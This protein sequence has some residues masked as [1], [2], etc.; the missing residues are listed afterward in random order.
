MDPTGLIFVAIGAFAVCGAGFDW[1]FFMNNRK[2]Q[3]MSA[4]LTRTGARIFY[5][6]LG[7]GLFVFG[8]LMA[9]GFVKDGQ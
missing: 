8:V 2:A 7:S 5:G 3:F 1:D 9:F 4:I 6:L